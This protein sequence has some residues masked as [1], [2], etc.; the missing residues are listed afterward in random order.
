MS[1]PALAVLQSLVL[2]SA[3]NGAPVLFARMLGPRFARPIDG[4]IVSRDGRPM[5][6]R[7]KTWR[8]LVSAFLLAVSVAVLIGLPWRLGALVAAS[9]MAG[10]CLSSFVKRRLGLEPS[11]MAL[12]LDQGPESLFPAVVCSAYLPLGAI[13]VVLIVVVFF[14]GGLAMSRLFFVVGL[15]DRPY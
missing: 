8:G 2:I 12:G 15:R 9:A 13:G 14:V 10:D 1:A 3:A 6:G 11:S 5:L 4:R 7:S